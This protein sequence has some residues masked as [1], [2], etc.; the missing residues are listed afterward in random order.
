MSEQVQ[1]MSWQTCRWINCRTG[2]A[3]NGTLD[4]NANNMTY[5]PISECD[6]SL[7]ELSEKYL[8]DKQQLACLRYCGGS[9]D[10]HLFI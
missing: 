4:S 3:A 6:F 7:L 2:F 8:C 10:C 9:R 5:R 1:N